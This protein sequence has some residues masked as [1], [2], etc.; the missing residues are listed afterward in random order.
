MRSDGPGGG[1]RSEV[2]CESCWEAGVAARQALEALE[3]EL[4]ERAEKLRGAWATA[5]AAKL[6]D[7][8]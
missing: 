4:Y 6:K 5:A 3:S 8:A 7:G 2:H 1:D